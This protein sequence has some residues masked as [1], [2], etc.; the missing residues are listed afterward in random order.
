MT[1]KEKAK[2]LIDKFSEQTF[3]QDFE[4]TKQCALICVEEILIHQTNEY[5]YVDIIT[6][7]WN[8]VKTE[9]NKL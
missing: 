3:N 5:G 4:E 6:E 8:E 9:I 2:H 1:P 7:Y